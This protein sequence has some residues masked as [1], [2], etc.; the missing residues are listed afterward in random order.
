ML[1]PAS[2][3]SAFT[4]VMHTQDVVIPHVLWDDFLPKRLGPI[5]EFED[6]FLTTGAATPDRG[7]RAVPLHSHMVRLY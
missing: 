4:A 5:A 6:D 1:S 7:V 2:E 3:P